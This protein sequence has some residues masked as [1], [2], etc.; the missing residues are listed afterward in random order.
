MKFFHT[1]SSNIWPEAVRS[2]TE[3]CFVETVLSISCLF[4]FMEI[5]IQPFVEEID[6]ILPT[7]RAAEDQEISTVQLLGQPLSRI[8]IHP[9]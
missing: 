1:T 2:Y 7:L 8:S 9:T 3:S 5:F 6:P 4:Y